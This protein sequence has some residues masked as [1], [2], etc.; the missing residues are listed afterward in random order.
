MANAVF[1]AAAISSVWWTFIRVLIAVAIG[2][3]VLWLGLKLLR[4]FAQPPPPP[5][6]PG[7]M[8]KVR[9]NYHCTICGA[10]VKMTNAPYEL[11][12]PPKHCGEEMNLITPLDD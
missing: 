7:A 10:E 8:R 2:L 1:L 3:L 6:P 4:F 5:P 11:P 12:D 9:L